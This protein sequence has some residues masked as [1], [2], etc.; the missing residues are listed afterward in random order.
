MHCRHPGAILGLRLVCQMGTKTTENFFPRPSALVTL[1]FLGWPLFCLTAFS[2]DFGG[3]FL[4][5][6]VCETATKR[7]HHTHT[8]PLRRGIDHTGPGR[9]QR[10]K[11]AQ[12]NDFFFFRTRL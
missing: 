8:L 1:F 7:G 11:K 6:G 4:T 9:K 10:R 3:F 12:R 2:I 5:T